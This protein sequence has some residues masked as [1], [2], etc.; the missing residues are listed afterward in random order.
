[1]LAQGAARARKVASQTMDAVRDR[2]GFLPAV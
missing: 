2:I 1:M